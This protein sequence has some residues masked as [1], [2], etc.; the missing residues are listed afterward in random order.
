MSFTS[1]SPARSSSDRRMTVDPADLAAMIKELEDEENEAECSVEESM[2]SSRAGTRPVAAGANP[3]NNSLLSEMSTDSSHGADKSC[4][5]ASFFSEPSLSSEASGKLQAGR[6]TTCDPL[7]IL[8]VMADLDNEKYDGRPE[9]DSNRRA[10]C[11]PS[12]ILAMMEDMEKDNVGDKFDRRM[13]ADPADMAAIMLGLEEEDAHDKSRQHQQGSACDSDYK[14][15]QGPFTG[16]ESMD[17]VF[18]V[19]SVGS[20]LRELEEAE[21]ASQINGCLKSSL[22]IDTRN[23]DSNAMDES[24]SLSLSS[25]AS[26]SDETMGTMDLIAT[27]QSAIDTHDDDDDTIMTSSSFGSIGGLLNMVVQA[28]HQQQQKPSKKEAVTFQSPRRSN[29][30]STIDESRSVLPVLG[31]PSQGPSTSPYKGLR[32]CLASRTKASSTSIAPSPAASTKRYVAFGSP[33]V[34]EFNKTSPATNMT[35]MR[36]EA[37]SKLFSMK[38][39]EDGEKVDVDN[40]DE[41]DRLTNT[42]GGSPNQSE[43]E[44]SPLPVPGS[45]A[46][47]RRYYT[48]NADSPASIVAEYSG[49]RRSPRRK[50]PSK[51]NKSDID[52]N[53]SVCSEVTGTVDLPNS[54]R[55]LMSSVEGCMAAGRSGKDGVI[56][57]IHSGANK[58][59]VS[60]VLNTSSLS[61]DQTEVLE[62]DLQSLIHRNREICP[63]SD[64]DDSCDQSQSRSLVELR[65]ADLS[66]FSEG[67]VPSLGPLLGLSSHST[68]DKCGASAEDDKGRKEEEYMMSSPTSSVGSNESLVS[69]KQT[70]DSNQNQNYLNVSTSTWEPTTQFSPTTGVSVDGVT[71]ELECRLQDLIQ[72]LGSPAQAHKKMKNKK[73]KKRRAPLRTSTPSLKYTAAVDRASPW[74]GDMSVI[75][76]VDD[77][78]TERLEGN[79]GDLLSSVESPSVDEKQDAYHA[80]EAQ[81]ADMHTQVMSPCVQ[82]SP[83]AV[84]ECDER[85]SIGGDMLGSPERPSSIR[86][87][88]IDYLNLISAPGI[89]TFSFTDVSVCADRSMDMSTARVR[90]STVEGVAMMRRLSVLNAG[91]RM[92]TLEQCA[93]PL[94]AKG[95]MSIGMKRHSLSVTR[96]L[97]QSNSKKSRASM[98]AASAITAGTFPSRAAVQKMPLPTILSQPVPTSPTPCGTADTLLTEEKEVT[99]VA[100]THSPD[101]KISVRVPTSSSILRNAIHSM[102]VQL[103]V[104]VGAE[105]ESCSVGRSDVRTPVF[106]LIPEEE[107]EV[108]VE[109][110]EDECAIEGVDIDTGIGGPVDE[111][112]VHQSAVLCEGEKNDKIEPSTPGIPQA[113]ALADNKEVLTLPQIAADTNTTEKAESALLSQ[114]NK[115]SANLAGKEMLRT[116][117][118]RLKEARTAL[119][120]SSEELR[121]LQG[122]MSLILE[123]KKD[124]MISLIEQKECSDKDLI[125]N[126]EREKLESEQLKA[127]AAIE[128]RDAEKSLQGVKQAMGLLNRV[129][130]CRVLRYQSTVIEI[131]A[132]LSSRLRVQLIF[133]LTGDKNTGKLLV[134]GTHVD[135]KY[136]DSGNR[137]PEIENETSL[138]SAYFSDIMC[139]GE[140]QGPLCE[141]LL[142]AVA[143]P[144]DIPAAMM[145]VRFHHL[146]SILFHP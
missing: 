3:A 122:E 141:G 46:F 86:S 56:R 123:K 113:I 96:Y 142:S 89:D 17:T 110:V 59:A 57:S 30:L 137:T 133:N 23:D 136:V 52:L 64:V 124:H 58:Q 127:E 18:L 2:T 11:D 69:F 38:L 115:M 146:S 99:D 82:D 48:S 24:L 36:K 97:A 41:W 22:P 31:T 121:T 32:S 132:V 94:A 102:N 73:T 145:R 95:S 92:N 16:R 25:T 47:N 77:D 135:L 105:V 66:R 26:D 39:K 109:V 80:Q 81:E 44:L 120:K 40:S 90:S 70:T 42:S 144:S 9:F 28:E 128:I 60:A 88:D 119:D 15:G 98:S 68:D 129:T 112:D 5:S 93:T 1:S 14:L 126:Q 78:H 106:A 107:S 118:I 12:D 130:Y 19:E 117:Q 104:Q 29:R 131:E 10:T 67:S 54:L 43:D 140:V 50:S 85:K 37:A 63:M 8:A 87:S 111:S 71:V 125:L 139:S 53:A 4:M 33:K 35:P 83:V 76:N 114:T 91:A 72:D 79:L 138:A 27:V 84:L 21:S 45:P 62:A 7:D 143:C 34:A 116:L 134:D 51:S 100:T 13:T 49:V 101:S 74:L 65:V 108:E 75:S 20:M 55:D 6:R 103:E 61:I